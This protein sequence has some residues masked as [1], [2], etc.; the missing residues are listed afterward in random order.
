MTAALFLLGAL[1]SWE[2][3]KSVQLLSSVLWH[4]SH[5]SERQET[6]APEGQHHS[7][8]HTLGKKCLQSASLSP[9]VSSKN[10]GQDQMKEMGT[11][12]PKA[13]VSLILNLCPPPLTDGGGA[14][15]LWVPLLPQCIQ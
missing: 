14:T 15:V 1:V 9:P 3:V 8:E 12:L 6:E 2:E 4:L 13:Q 7:Q 5:P 11:V 10:P